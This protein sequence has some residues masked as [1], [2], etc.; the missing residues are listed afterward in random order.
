MAGVGVG[1]Y[2]LAL[3]LGLDAE[4]VAPLVHTIVIASCMSAPVFSEAC[5]T[6]KTARGV[7]PVTLNTHAKV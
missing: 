5:V 1:V 7:S 3:G 6:A 2:G 4:M